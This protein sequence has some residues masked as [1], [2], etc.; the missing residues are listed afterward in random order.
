MD[1]T[2]RNWIANIKL[3]TNEYLLRGFLRGFLLKVV[4]VKWKWITNLSSRKSRSI[5]ILPFDSFTKDWMLDIIYKN[6]C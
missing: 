4:D 2:I 1:E 6:M 3:Q 5:W